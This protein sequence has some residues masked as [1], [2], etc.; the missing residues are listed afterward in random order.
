[1]LYHHG[2]EQSA[3]DRVAGALFVCC[4][5]IT[6]IFQIF[7][8]IGYA[9]M[10]SR[11][12][13]VRFFLLCLEKVVAFGYMTSFLLDNYRVRICYSLKMSSQRGDVV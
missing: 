7:L 5:T 1:M 2:E 9:I 13:K 4:A 3:G 10:S 12:C 8:P 6:K 11:Y